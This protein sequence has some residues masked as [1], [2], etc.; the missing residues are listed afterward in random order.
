LPCTRFNIYKI[1]SGLIK[2]TMRGWFSVLVAGCPK[3]IGWLAQRGL[4][5][6]SAVARALSLLK[7]R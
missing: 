4:K 7:K 3:V 2:L 1:E 6:P 5:G